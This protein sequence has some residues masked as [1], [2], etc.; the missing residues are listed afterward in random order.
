M[1][2]TDATKM[3]TGSEVNDQ[4][5]GRQTQ[6]CSVTVD[7]KRSPTNKSVIHVSGELAHGATA[8]M[9]QVVATELKRSP[10]LLALDL[11]EVNRQT[12]TRKR[13]NAGHGIGR[14]RSGIDT[15][16][17]S[18]SATVLVCRA[19]TSRPG[20]VPAQLLTQV[21]SQRLAQPCHLLQ[22]RIVD[23]LTRPA[24]QHRAQLSLQCAPD[25]AFIVAWLRAGSGPPIH[26]CTVVQTFPAVSVWST[27]SSDPRAGA[28]L[29][30][31][32]ADRALEVTSGTES[33]AAGVPVVGDI[34]Q[35]GTREDRL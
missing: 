6:T 22:R 25:R 35:M 32:G 20:N 10:A 8:T 21:T 23:R 18:S 33:F 27:A 34:S 19:S 5:E 13:Q 31:A 26:P 1:D 15:T 7:V 16:G 3:R 29:M 9:R 17:L 11:T 2:S 4:A 30:T 14:R 12:A 28:C 24:P